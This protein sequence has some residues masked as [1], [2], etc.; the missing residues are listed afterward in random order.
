MKH[1]VCWFD[2]PFLPA[3]RTC[4]CCVAALEPHRPQVLIS[5]ASQRHKAR[6]AASATAQAASRQHWLQQSDCA[7]FP[8]SHLLKDCCHWTKTAQH[9]QLAQ[10]Q[11]SAALKED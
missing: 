9:H 4:C 8:C 11:H 2:D 7:S 5:S 6:L 3:S 10:H 1:V